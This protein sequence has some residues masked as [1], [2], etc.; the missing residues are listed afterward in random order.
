MGF[1]DGTWFQ[2]RKAVRPGC[3]SEPENPVWSALDRTSEAK[4]TGEGINAL[5]LNFS[6][7]KGQ[8]AL[9]VIKMKGKKDSISNRKRA[10]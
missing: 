1:S 3:V 5:D 2:H 8:S 4:P 6:M 10:P 7:I 9:L